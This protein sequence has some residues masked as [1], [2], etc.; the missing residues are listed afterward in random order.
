MNMKTIIAAFAVAAATVASASTFEWQLN[1]DYEFKNKN[2]VA[3]TQGN[4]RMYANNNGSNIGS[5]FGAYYFNKNNDTWFTVDRDNSKVFPNYAKN[6]AYRYSFAL[7]N[8]ANDAWYLDQ[9]TVE[10]YAKIGGEWTYNGTTYKGFW[11][12]VD[13]VTKTSDFRYDFKDASGNVFASIK[14]AGPVPEPT[15]GLMLLLGAGMLALRRKAV[16]A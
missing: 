11:N 12:M 8:N 6:N 4:A 9:A 1:P 14:A 3:M 7:V 10:M 13:E 16:R 2:G 15:S 5:Q